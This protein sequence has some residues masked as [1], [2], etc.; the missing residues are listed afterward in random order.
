MAFFMFL[1]ISSPVAFQLLNIF[2]WS[3][4]KV[5]FLLPTVLYSV[6]SILSSDKQ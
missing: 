4:D 5:M 1:F 6:F 3:T 2:I